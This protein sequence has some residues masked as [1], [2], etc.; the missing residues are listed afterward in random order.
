M[1]RQ[2]AFCISG[3]PACVSV[4]PSP[5]QSTREIPAAI[6]AQFQSRDLGRGLRLP[7]VSRQGKIPALSLLYLSWRHMSPFFCFNEQI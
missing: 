1:M 3:E 5:F 7:N 2:I 6:A 4:S